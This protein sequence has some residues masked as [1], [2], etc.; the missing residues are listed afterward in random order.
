MSLVT[1]HLDGF[2]ARGCLLSTA[3][4]SIARDLRLHRLDANNELSTENEA[5]VRVLIDREVKRRVFWYIA[6]TDW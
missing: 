2:S 5:S 4:A 6:S 1:Y 3:A